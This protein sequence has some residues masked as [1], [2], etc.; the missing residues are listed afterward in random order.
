MN[1]TLLTPSYANKSFTH[2]RDNL[3]PLEE[4]FAST[5]LQHNFLNCQKSIS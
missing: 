2:I 3:F 1:Q 5:K 4:H